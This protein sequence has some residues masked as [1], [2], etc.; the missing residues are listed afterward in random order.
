MQNA[1]LTNAVVVGFQQAKEEAAAAEAAL[2]EKERELRAWLKDLDAKK[3]ME[4]QQL[5]TTHRRRR[6][7]ECLSFLLIFW[8]GG[9]HAAPFIWRWRLQVCGPRA[10]NPCKMYRCGVNRMLKG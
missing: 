6:W 10:L 1:A 9:G 7:Q 5:S 2:R 4:A 8:R 3:V